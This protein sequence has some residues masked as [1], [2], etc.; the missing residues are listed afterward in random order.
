MNQHE[1]VFTIINRLYNL[2]GTPKWIVY[3][4]QYH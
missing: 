1:S 3:N 2:Y 4:G